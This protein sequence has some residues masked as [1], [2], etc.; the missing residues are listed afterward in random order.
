[1]KGP[2]GGLAY[3]L[4]HMLV[5]L[6]VRNLGVIAQARVAFAEGM[7]ALTGETGAGK[8]MLVE[9]LRLLCGEKADPTRVRTGADE[10]VVEGLFAVGDTE[11]VLRRVVPAKGRSRCYLNGELVPAARLGEISRELVEIHGQHGQQALLDPRAQRAAL[12]AFGGVGTAALSDARRELAAAVEEMEALGGD[13]RARQRQL[14]LLD[15]QIREIEAVA[16]LP[17]EDEDLAA[18]ETLLAGAMQYREAASEASEL[19][20]S[21]GAAADMLAR[22]ADSLGE[23]GPFAASSQ[24]IAGL[25]AELT[26]VAAEVRAVGEGIEPDEERLAAVRER[27]QALVELRRKY[28]DSTEEVL[29][30]LGGARDE[31]EVLRSLDERRARAG[32]RI[33]EARLAVS[34]EAG[35]VGEAR[36][37][38]A[39]LLA[40]EVTRL[41]ADLAL[42]GASVEVGV[43]DTDTLP[44]AGE[45]VEFRLAA[46]AGSPPAPLAKAAS[47][48]E[49]SRVMLALRVVLSGGPATMVFDEVDAGVGGTAATAGGSALSRLGDER[50]VLVVTHLAQVA[51]A[52]AAQVAVDKRSDGSTTLTEVRSLDTDE[53]VVEISRMLSGSPESD[54]AR[55]HAEELLAGRPV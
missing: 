51:A 18:E 3:A 42:G 6:A 12:D 32:E 17:D 54:S 27:R 46:N 13:D 37:E 10:A 44:L 26:D 16:P 23:D 19:L 5:E 24:R 7:T 9:A 34:V 11:W 2:R 50:Q 43:H 40:A 33:E 29:E 25:L 49:L 47:G 22:A 21:D 38:A 52:S 30:F 8:T 45:A 41:L 20:S 35:R 36:R 31:L 55:A 53:R 1:M 28:G 48:G 39:P 14:D 4:V 15:F